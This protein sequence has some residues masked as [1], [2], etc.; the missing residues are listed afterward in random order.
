VDFYAVWC[1]PCKRLAP[2]LDELAGSLT[3]RVKFVKVN[4]D[5]APALARQYGVE[6]VPTLLFFRN[7]KV[8]GNLVGLPPAEALKARVASLAEAGAAAV[9]EERGL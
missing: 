1:G 2:L 3:N 9:K 6:A 7:G 4:I 8:V 5:E